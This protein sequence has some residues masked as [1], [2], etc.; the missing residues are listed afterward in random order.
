MKAKKNVTV[1]DQDGNISKP[2]LC[3]V[4][5]TDEQWEEWRTVCNIVVQDAI[6]GHKNVNDTIKELSSKFK[7]LSV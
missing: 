7:L 3:D 5:L 4:I 6:F 1:Q 2:L